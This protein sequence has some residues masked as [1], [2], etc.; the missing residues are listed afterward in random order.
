MRGTSF[1][2]TELEWNSAELIIRQFHRKIR[3]VSSGNGSRRWSAVRLARGV[4]SATFI[5]KFEGC[6]TAMP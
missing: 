3:F 6:Y 5:L 4:T 1:G 2:V